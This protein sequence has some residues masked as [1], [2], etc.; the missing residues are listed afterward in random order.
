MTGSRNQIIGGNGRRVVQVIF[1]A[2]ALVTAVALTPSLS[3]VAADARDG[4]RLGQVVFPATGAPA[5]HAH[6]VRG[7]AALHSFWYEEAI[8]AFQ[9]ALKVDSSF[10]M[11]WWGIAMAFNRPFVPG[12]DLEAGRRALAHIRSAGH[13]RTRVKLR[14][15]QSA[16]V[17]RCE[18][19]ALNGS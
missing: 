17:L 19:S 11:A 14:L 7:V 5:A 6:F 15:A 12:S 2:S 9:E 10:A 1:M 18:H 8:A 13:R 4:I 16:L 3:T